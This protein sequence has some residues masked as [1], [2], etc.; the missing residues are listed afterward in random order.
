MSSRKFNDASIKDLIKL[1]MSNAGLE[2]KYN[3][4]E[5]VKCYHDVMGTMISKRTVDAKVEDRK[6]ILKIDSGVLRE[7][8]SLNKKRIIDLVNER[9]GAVVVEAVEI[10]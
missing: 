7:E 4:L 10:R 8:L 5:I 6:L 9:F 1:M 2:K 3:E